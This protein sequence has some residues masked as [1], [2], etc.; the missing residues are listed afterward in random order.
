MVGVGID[1]KI[2]DMTS[3]LSILS[4]YP[5][6][7]VINSLCPVFHHTYKVDLK[8]TLFNQRK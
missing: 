7:L 8:K 5:V 1:L 6:N 3:Y 2:T 4:T